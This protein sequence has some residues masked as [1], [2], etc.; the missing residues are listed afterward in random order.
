[1]HLIAN[2]LGVKLVDS[3]NTLLCQT[4]E[5]ERILIRQWSYDWVGVATIHLNL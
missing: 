3:L 5:G 2:Q 1:M 4:S